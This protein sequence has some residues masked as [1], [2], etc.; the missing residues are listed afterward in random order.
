MENIDIKMLDANFWQNKA[1]SQK[2]VKEK[3]LLP[4][5]MLVKMMMNN[6]TK[7]YSMSMG[8]SVTSYIL[9]H[10]ICEGYIDGVD[11]KINDWP[12]IK[13]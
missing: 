4:G 8:K 11:S 1:I 10:A 12:V 3:S 7:F 9:G 13:D 6:E 2:T 5:Y